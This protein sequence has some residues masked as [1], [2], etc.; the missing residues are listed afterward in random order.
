MCLSAIY[1]ARLD[2]LYFAAS[3]LDAAGIGFDDDFLYLELGRGS[4]DRKLATRQ[5]LREDAVRMMQG[6][7]A[8]PAERR[9]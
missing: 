2:A 1:W 9:Y 5:A 3:R 6:W 8:M 7:T 4:A